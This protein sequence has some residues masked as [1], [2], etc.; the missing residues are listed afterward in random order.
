MVSPGQLRLHTR[1]AG[2]G[3]CPGESAGRLSVLASPSGVDLRNPE[4]WRR[5][6]SPEPAEFLQRITTQPR[7]HGSGAVEF[8]GVNSSAKKTIDLST[9][10]S[11]C[12]ACLPT[13]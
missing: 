10:N 2:Q 13:G 9:K 6:L 8:L 3:V 1:E 11:N 4:C 12:C 7:F 5:R